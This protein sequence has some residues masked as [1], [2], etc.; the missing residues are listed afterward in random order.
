[1]EIHCSEVLADLPLFVG[2]DLEAPSRDGVAEHFEGCAPCRD[3]LTRASAARSALSEHMERTAATPSDSVW[4]A[5]RERLRVEGLVH[6]QPLVA[7]SSGGAGRLL[8]F[9]PHAAA[10]AALL[11]AGVLSGQWLNSGE[12]LPLSPGA[13][14]A[15]PDTPAPAVRGPIAEGPKVGE[16]S[17]QPVAPSNPAVAEA[18]V[19]PAAGLRAVEDGEALR[20][21]ASLFVD[22][23]I[24]TFTPF[25]AN[26]MRMA[27]F[28][29]RSPQQPPTIDRTQ[30][31]LL[32]R[33][34]R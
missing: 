32:K 5:L 31:Q 23:P 13:N 6:G 8:R 11:A 22:Q 18:E 2:G 25:Q 27:S 21:R 9:L 20:D 1:M 24:L 34:I 3:A 4:P 15:R 16:T 17:I 14:I 28:G 33:G 26:Q 29:Q 7:A 19:G 12:G 10:A 30:L